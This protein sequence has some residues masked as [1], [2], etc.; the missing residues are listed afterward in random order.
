MKLPAV[1]PSFLVAPLQRGMQS[2]EKERERE[3]VKEREMVMVMQSI[4]R[5][6]TCVC[7]DDVD[8]DDEDEEE[9]DQ[10]WGGRLN[11]NRQATYAYLGWLV[12]SRDKLVGNVASSS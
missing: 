12:R 1:A 5:W 6:N 9:N 10:L 8:D 3:R 4:S 7:K 11:R 2:R